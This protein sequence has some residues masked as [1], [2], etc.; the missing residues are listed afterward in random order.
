M[1]ET[2]VGKVEVGEYF[3]SVTANGC[4]ALLKIYD[5]SKSKKEADINSGETYYLQ[6]LTPA[7]IISKEEAFNTPVKNL[8]RITKF[9]ELRTGAHF[10]E[11]PHGDEVFIKSSCCRGFS[12][13]DYFLTEIK[14]ARLVME[15]E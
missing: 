11:F 10:K 8:D 12:L 14:S 2:T 9:G 6:E 3:L 5:Y 13:K 4:K 1:K 15:V 7:F